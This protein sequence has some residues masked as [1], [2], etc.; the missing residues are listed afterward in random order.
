MQSPNELKTELLS[1]TAMN[2]FAKH[3]SS[4]RSV[5]MSSH[6]SQHLVINGL[7]ERLIQSG[8]EQQFANHTFSVKMPNNGRIIKVIERYPQGIDRDSLPFNPET[9]V[10]Y[11][12]EDT[13]EVDCFTIPHYLCLH[14]FF[15]F[16]Y[17]HTGAINQ[18]KPGMYI[19]KDTKF[20]DTPG[21][22]DH[23]SYMY[24]ANLNVAFM[25]IPSV[26][27]DGVMVSEDV[28]DKLKFKIYET[29]TVSFGSTHFPLNIHGSPKNYKP[30][31]EIGDYINDT[32][33]DG[34]LMALRGYSDTLSITDM[35]IY[36]TTEVDFMFDKAVFARPGGR[37][38]VVDIQVISN[39]IRDRKLPEEM[40]DHISKYHR[41]YMKYY[42]EIINT[43]V[44]MRYDSNR[45]F[46]FNSLRLSPKFHALLVEAYAATNQPIPDE[47][48]P[49]N[50][51]Y[52]KTPIDEYMIKFVVEYEITPNIG[53]KITDCHGGF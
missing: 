8:V 36:D 4:S 13:K 46:G 26:S 16:E 24:G 17:K 47:S 28:L 9:L 11:E 45:K 6:I 25:S 34:L 49:L 51:Q 43:E 50:I 1:I 32:R 10:I 40:A 5:M 22:S 37:G 44:K 42:Q 19:G 33:Q 14:Q 21:V 41:A 23:N 15:G 29:R 31:P 3:N 39:N 30:F 27:E 7:E 2:P 52:R 48:K 12:I 38:K 20:S 35:S 53:F 18:I